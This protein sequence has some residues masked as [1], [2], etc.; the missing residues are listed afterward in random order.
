MRPQGSAETIDIMSKE[1]KTGSVR[2]ARMEAKKLAREGVHGHQQALDQVA[3]DRG[4]RN[5]SA[6]LASE[7]QGG[8]RGASEHATKPRMATARDVDDHTET[9]YLEDA[10]ELRND[11]PR[12]PLRLTTVLGG[13]FWM[14]MLLQWPVTYVEC[15]SA[16]CLYFTV[17]LIAGR[18]AETREDGFIVAR[19][20]IQN[21][22]IAIGLS[23]VAI[24]AVLFAY[25]LYYYGQHDA[26]GGGVR[27]P[28]FEHAGLAYTVG[29]TALITS[30][31]VHRIMT[32]ASPQSVR[33]VSREEITFSDGTKVRRPRL[34]LWLGS[35]MY[36]GLFI[37]MA[38]IVA[39]AILTV[40]FLITR[41][42]STTFFM[43][44]FGVLG[45]GV[46]VTLIA[47]GGY[48][49]IVSGT[50]VDAD[51]TSLRRRA[52]RARR[53]LQAS[54]RRSQTA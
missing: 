44:S 5:W 27:H 42:L 21:W 39:V 17:T 40:S 18:I 16:M 52:A 36:A 2:E 49:A 7:G 51:S 12:W 3:R 14:L 37:A 29:I 9:V 43:W 41:E 19:R 8:V 24:G 53:L 26:L 32:V 54:T 46:L 31:R 20:R 47:M 30:Q 38:G 33:P 45:A 25:G 6:F 48:I 4:H 23:L 1:T 13:A 35:S 34:E 11:H 50:G 28:L 10:A 15:I 22:G